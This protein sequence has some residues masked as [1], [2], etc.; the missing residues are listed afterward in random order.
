MKKIK[1]VLMK[2][3]PNRIVLLSRFFYLPPF[4]HLLLTTYKSYYETNL[5]SYGKHNS[6]IFT[7]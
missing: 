6:R 1:I 3:E 2:Y 4:Y 7:P 5:I